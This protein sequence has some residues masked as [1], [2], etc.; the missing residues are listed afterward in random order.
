MIVEP[1]PDRHAPIAPA[2]RAAL[3]QRGQL[4]DRPSARYGSW[5]RS[6]VSARAGRAGRS[7]CRRRR[8]RPRPGS[9]PRRRSGTFAGRTA[10]IAVGRE[11]QLRDE[12]HRPQVARCVEP[13]APRRA[14]SIAA[15]RRRTRRAARP[16]R[17]RDGPR[18]RSRAAAGSAV[19]KRPAERARCRRRARATVAAADDPSP[20]ASGIA[21]CISI[22]QPTPSGSSPRAAAS[23]ASRPR[24]NRLSRS[25]GELVAP[26]PSTVSSISPR[27]QPRTST[28]TRL[29]SAER[30]A[31]AVVPGAE[32][33]RDAGTSTR[34]PAAV[35][36]GQPVVDHAV[37]AASATATAP[38][39]GVGLDDRRP[40]LRARRSSG[41]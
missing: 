40:D 39:V 9:R 21:L 24:T 32:I 38:T 20:R 33:G 6:T 4:R 3:D 30:H 2:S 13:D 14:P 10:R 8:S 25:V 1:A 16:R 29:V 11:P 36:L 28:S 5:S 34:D 7:P 37:R 41:P 23:A 19:V 17:C 22:R 31:E 18:S 12:Q 27:L 35:E 26:S 15:R